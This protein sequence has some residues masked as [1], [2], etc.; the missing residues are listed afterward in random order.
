MNVQRDSKEHPQANYDIPKVVVRFRTGFQ[1]SN[2]SDLGEQLEKAG[3]APWKKLL[4]EF[5]GLT[6]RPAF[7]PEQIN[8]L[9]RLT[10]IAIESDP[11][12]VPA[13]FQS[14]FYIAAPPADDLIQLVQAVLKWRSVSEAYIDQ[15]G[16]DPVV[17]ETN[18]PMAAFQGYLEPAPDG[19][20][21]KYAWKFTGGDGAGQNIIDMERGWTLNHEDLIDQGATLK[22]GT[23]NDDSRRHGTAVLGVICAV[24]NSIGCVG[25]APKIKSVIVV[26]YH[27]STRVEAITAALIFLTF[28]DLLLCEAQVYLNGTDLL[29][30]IE[31]YDLEYEVI[32]LATALGVIVVEAGG[33]GT[34]TTALDLDNYK[35]ATGRAILNR[36]ATNPDFR[37][38]GAIIVSAATSATP[39]TRLN[40]APHGKRIDC[41]AWGE[42]IQTLKS[43]P[44]GAID[45]Y[46]SGFS[47][48]SGASAIIAGAVLAVQGYASAHLGFPMSP[49]QMRAILSDGATGTSPSAS[50]TTKIGVMPNLRK[51][52]DESFNAVPDVYIRDFVGDV[53][54]SHSGAISASPD[55]ILRK[56]EVI[57]SQTA[58]GAG[59]GT[60]NDDTLGST[61]EIGQDNFIYV[62]L[63][64]RGATNANNVTA[65]VYWSPVA[66]LVTP[67]LWTLVGSTIL[68]TV[69]T[70]NLLTSS[71]AIVWDKNSLPA[72]GHYC[73]VGLVGSTVDPAPNP[74]DFENW[75]NFRRFIRE[76]N[77]VTWRNFN[78]IDSD[79]GDAGPTL[80]KFLAIGAPDKAR[81][82]TLEF[83]STLPAESRIGVEMPLALRDLMIANNDFGQTFLDHKTDVAVVPINPHVRTRF[84]AIPFPARSRFGLRLRV[85]IP[86]PHRV[87]AY[88][89]VVRQIWEGEE[90]GRI[91][92]QLQSKKIAVKYV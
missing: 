20:D 8:E 68:S 55:I 90:V 41:Y 91:T 75:D 78:V 85:Q 82:M 42:N 79:P 71:D 30:P 74:A 67:D 76:N 45:K 4:S 12:Y 10:L 77:N 3:I 2:H 23:I 57:D 92:W 24:D 56:A 29:G 25:I 53:G 48:T 19:I 64:N 27:G 89:I 61:V 17:D 83:S 60:E 59:S 50:E 32:R 69:L 66:T 70:G 16:P 7:S 80:L 58:F 46:T 26:S 63:L 31:A 9:K 22:H 87:N 44:A 33:N 65:T 11:T 86:E 6:I 49:K 13:D 39:H 52:L 62:R 73:F 43:D 15:A 5:P 36:D 37:D 38:S 88:R 34:E 40:Y 28:G 72:T 18:D 35:T 14:F 1:F 21:A 47:G 51:I 81:P 54:D 84:E